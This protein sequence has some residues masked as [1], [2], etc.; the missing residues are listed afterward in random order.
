MSSLAQLGVE[1]DQCAGNAHLHGIGLRGNA[2][3]FT[4]VTTSKL[5]AS[6]ATTSVRLAAYALLLG[7]EVLVESLAVDLPLARAGTQKDAGDRRLAPPRPVI[8]N[9]ICHSF[10]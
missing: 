4:V 10:S 1:L 6:S 8:L 5:D 9:Q 7:D 2:A 3:A